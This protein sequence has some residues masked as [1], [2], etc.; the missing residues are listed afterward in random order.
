MAKVH[1]RNHPESPLQIISFPSFLSP[2]QF[3][4]SL[5]RA[6]SKMKKAVNTCIEGDVVKSLR[7]RKTAKIKSILG[8]FTIWISICSNNVPCGDYPITY[9]LKLQFIMLK[10]QENI[11]P[12]LFGE[13]KHHWIAPG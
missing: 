8:I 9:K 3:D 6:R 12:K 10:L 7:G 2:L 4:G 13:G 1:R 11:V 5:E